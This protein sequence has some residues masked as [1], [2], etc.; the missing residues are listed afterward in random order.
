[1]NAAVVRAAGGVVVRD[2]GGTLEVVLVHRPQYDDWTLPKG[3]ALPDES[4]DAC[5]L[6]EVEEE[7]GLRCLLE[8]ELGTTSYLD[9]RAR[10]KIARYWLMRPVGG[11]LSPAHEVDDARWVSLPEAVELLTHERD[12]ELLRALPASY[13]SPPA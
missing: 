5:A 7:T 12:R 1:V 8:A 9:A 2:G 4:D 10:P 6:R 11:R 3:K 13:L